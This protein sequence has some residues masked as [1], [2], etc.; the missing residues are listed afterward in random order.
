M[1]GDA[2]S[3]G[4]TP[5]AINNKKC[6]LN[7][8]VIN[9]EDP[10]LQCG[11][12]KRRVHLSC[13]LLPPYQLQRFLMFGKSYCVYICANCVEVP[14]DLQKIV[15]RD[16]QDVFQEKYERELNRTTNLK[17]EITSLHEKIKHQDGELKDLKATLQSMTGTDIMNQKQ[18]KRKINKDIINDD[19]TIESAEKTSKEIEILKKQNET[20]SERLDEREAA[21]DEALQQLADAADNDFS[22]DDTMENNALLDK[23]ENSIQNRFNSMQVNLI[24]MIDKKLESNNKDTCNKILSYASTVTKNIDTINADSDPSKE[25]K[26]PLTAPTVEDF[27][28]I[29]MSTR[30]EE[31][32]EEREKKERCC[33]II[34]HGIEESKD[35][36]V[37]VKHLLKKVDEYA[38]PK[39][40]TRI[41]RSENNKRKPM[42][43]VMRNETDKKSIMNNLRRLKGIVEYKGISITEDYTLS[44]RNMIREYAEKVREKNQLEPEESNYIWRLRGTPKNGLV[45]KRFMKVNLKNPFK[46][47]DR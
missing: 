30:N 8:C 3:T 13:T 33:N 16:S 38:I 36:D 47:N 23:I 31:L 42:K 40:I 20:L 17:K 18:K 9:E 5:E 27:R 26:S 43:V 7:T 2:S 12:C 34:I 1:E 46:A 6:T 32:A 21:L 35:D 11:T 14:L 39:N 45:L 15:P 25:I 10:K 28:S 22:L 29:M 24:N 41:G 37:F 44:E 19:T 4:I